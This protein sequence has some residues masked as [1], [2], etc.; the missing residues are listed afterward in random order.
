MA[1]FLDLVLAG[2]ICFGAAPLDK[3]LQGDKGLQ[4]DKGL[5]SLVRDKARLALMHG[6]PEK[7]N[8]EAN[9]AVFLKMLDK[10]TEKKAEIFIT[11]ECWLDG[12]AAPDKTSTPERLRSVAQRLDGSQYLKRVA[13]EAKKRGMFICFGFT[14]LEDGKIFNAAGLWNAEGKL[15]GVY[16]KTHLQTHDLQFSPGMAL[17][18]WPTPWGPV[19]IMIC[20]DRRWPETARTLRLQ[21][22][23]LILNPTYGFHGDF[24][25]AM[26]RTRAYEN[27]CF[28]AFAHPKVSL[29]TDPKGNVIAKEENDTPGLLICDV[30]LDQAKDESHLRDR[31]PDLYGILTQPK[32]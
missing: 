26:M 4:T 20:A 18:V 23:R 12:Y 10:A 17:P 6:V 31:R 30:S 15:V 32:P 9:F 21:G 13:E 27:Q 3:G 14:S 19:G 22:A 28:I 16:H 7:R 1:A 29:V 24:N 2:L 11:P 25:E 8:L 5:Q